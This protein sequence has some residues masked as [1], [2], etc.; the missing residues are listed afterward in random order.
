MDEL[1]A[2]VEPSDELRVL[3]QDRE[4]AFHVAGARTV[5]ASVAERRLVDLLRR[6]FDN[7]EV[8]AQEDLRLCPSDWAGDK[9]FVSRRRMMPDVDFGNTLEVVQ[10][11]LEGAATFLGVSIRAWDEDK[12]AGERSEAI[13]EFVH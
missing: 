12:I 1:R 13:V 9:R 6:V 11:E 8:T 10:E 4:R 5:N 7:I 2:E 3:G